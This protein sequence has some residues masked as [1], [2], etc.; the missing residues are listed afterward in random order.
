MNVLD[1]LI[2]LFEKGA[3]EADAVVHLKVRHR[4]FLCGHTV[5]TIFRQG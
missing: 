3:P 4:R 2:L 1:H 5:P